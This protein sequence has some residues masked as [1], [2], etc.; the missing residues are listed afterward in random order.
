[1]PVPSRFLFGC[2]YVSLLNSLLVAALRWHNISNALER[3]ALCND[4]STA[5]F[6]LKRNTSSTKWVIFLE[7]GGGCSSAQSCNERFID[8]VIRRKYTRTEDGERHVDVVRAWM[9]YEDRPLAATSKLMTSLWRF[10]N[11]TSSWSI[12]GRDIFARHKRINPDFYTH[13]HVLIPYCSS[14]LWLKQSHNYVVA[15]NASFKFQFD[16]DS[17]QQQFTFRG[18]AILRSAVGDLFAHFGL[19]RADDV[20]FAGSSAGGVGVLNHAKW[21]RNELDVRAPGSSLRV[22][23]DSAWFIDFQGNIDGVITPGELQRNDE[24]I[25]TCGMDLGDP[26]ACISA[27]K[28]LLNPSLY[29]NVPTFAIVSVYDL[30]L[31]AESLRGLGASDVLEILRTVS[32]Y[33]GSMNTSLLEAQKGFG[34]LSVYVT[35]CFQHVYLATS[36]LWGGE[37]SLFGNASIDATHGNNHFRLANQKQR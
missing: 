35:S 6:F 32:E 23:I 12:K 29:P 24:I 37:G 17:K 14:D 31:L 13:N 7:G 21:L 33:S 10:S 8:H 25:E 20:I 19:N 11:A 30:Y 27:P 1:M 2:L 18:I 26:S 15:Q 4:F 34:N 28:V 5:G 3:G 16:P 22:V 36:T 9:D